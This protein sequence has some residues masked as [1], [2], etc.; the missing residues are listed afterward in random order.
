MF[1]QSKTGFSTNLNLWFQDA[2]HFLFPNVCVCCGTALYAHE[3][4]ICQMCL[5]ELPQT[6]FHLEEGNPVEKVF[7]GRVSLQTATSVFHFNKGNRVQTLIH[8]LKYKNRPDVGHELGRVFGPGLLSNHSLK[9]AHAFVPVPL[10]PDKQ[11]KRGY[12]QSEELAKGFAASMNIPVWNQALCRK[13][14]TAT[15]TKKSRT[16]R[17]ENVKEVFCVENPETIAGKDL[18]L[19]D[20]VVTTGATIEACAQ[21]LLD[22]GCNSVSLL[23][24]AFT[25]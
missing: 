2:I 19:V 15:Q 10:H 14:A 18:I 8:T 11:Q 23:A 1:Y 4:V 13:V 7:W 6:F 22:A 5:T 3:P 12:N 20:D 21:A 24:L 17:W 16:D 25:D 9:G